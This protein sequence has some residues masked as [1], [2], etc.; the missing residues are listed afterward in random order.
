M[1]LRKL[2]VALVVSFP[3]L[4]RGE[5]AWV[6]LVAS[7]VL[8]VGL[9]YLSAAGKIVMRFVARSERHRRKRPPLPDSNSLI[10]ARVAAFGMRTSKG[11]PF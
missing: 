10:A 2:P 11:S 6:L 3:T 9:L 7:W 1:Q 8:L 5:V 4:R